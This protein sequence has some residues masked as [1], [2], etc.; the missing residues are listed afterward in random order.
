MFNSYQEKG[1]TIEETYLEKMYRDF[2]LTE[3]EIVEKGKDSMWYTDLILCLAIRAA[4]QDDIHADCKTETYFTPTFDVDKITT[5]NDLTNNLENNYSLIMNIIGFSVL[6]VQDK[7]LQNQSIQD[8]CKYFD[9]IIVNSKGK[10]FITY[11]R[12]LP[13]NPQNVDYR[14]TNPTNNNG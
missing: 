14:N 10:H 7:E 1:K 4:L 9:V 13:V 8:Y 12:Y 3:N 11:F 5:L 2:I 6:Y